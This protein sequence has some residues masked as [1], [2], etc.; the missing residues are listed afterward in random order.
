MNYDNKIL[1]YL[2]ILKINKN[3]LII[4]NMYNNNKLLSL[5]LTISTRNT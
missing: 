2:L 1:I 5:M 4:K 3:N